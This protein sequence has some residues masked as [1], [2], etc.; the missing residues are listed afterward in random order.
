MVTHIL[1]PG[2]GFGITLK[3]DSIAACLAGV[4]AVGIVP[5]PSRSCMFSQAICVYVI[6]CAVVIPLSLF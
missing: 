2:L 3:N 5:E 4:L 6:D 1:D